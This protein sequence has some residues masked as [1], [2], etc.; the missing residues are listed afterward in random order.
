M[1]NVTRFPSGWRRE[2][3]KEKLPVTLLVSLLQGEKALTG[4]AGQWFDSNFD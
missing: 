2:T 3:E 4:M 1:Y